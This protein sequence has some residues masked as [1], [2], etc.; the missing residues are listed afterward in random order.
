MTAI[1]R[2]RV[3]PLNDLGHVVAEMAR[4]YREARVGDLD[5]GEAT[6]LVTMLREVRCA[7]EVR[8]VEQRLKQLEEKM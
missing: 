1:R 7:L 8:D 2:K 6:K 3:G 4:V 5:T